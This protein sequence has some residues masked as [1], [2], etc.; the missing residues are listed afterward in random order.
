MDRFGLAE[1]GQISIDLDIS[2]DYDA[3]ESILDEDEDTRFAAHDS[4]VEDH[5]TDLE[6][7]SAEQFPEED[8]D[9]AGTLKAVV[10]ILNSK[11]VDRYSRITLSC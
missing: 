1:N 5:S 7:F 8:D 11:Q 3:V 10:L 6:R 2:V 4:A 9:F